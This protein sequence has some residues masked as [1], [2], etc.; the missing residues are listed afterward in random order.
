MM[1]RLS[2]NMHPAL[3]GIPDWGP[4]GF[5]IGMNGLN[6]SSLGPAS[7]LQV[8]SSRGE[9]RGVAVVFSSCRRPG[10]SRR[11]RVT[12][13]PFLVEECVCGECR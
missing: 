6:K 9:K 11:G 1:E 12:L 5:E 13:G 10:S 3:T 7:R 4:S 2:S 8:L